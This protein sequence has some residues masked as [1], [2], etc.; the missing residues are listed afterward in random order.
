MLFRSVLLGFFLGLFYECF[1]FLRLAFPHPDFLVA[2]EDLIFFFPV[3]FLFLLFNYALSEGIIRWFSFAGMSIGFFLYLNTLGK[4]ILFFSEVI[5]KFFRAILR[6]LFKTLLAPLMIIFK[7]ITNCLWF[8]IKQ[9]AIISTTKIS[10]FQIG[11]RK[12]RLIKKS[13]RGF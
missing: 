2:L 13:K 1:R 10:L 3:S 7:N 8:G 9:F 12:K 5:L 4:I 11:R 6:F